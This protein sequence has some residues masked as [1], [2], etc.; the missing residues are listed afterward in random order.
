MPPGMI[1][2]RSMLSCKKCSVKRQGQSMAI[3]KNGNACKYVHAKGELSARHARVCVFRRKSYVLASP[4][5]SYWRAMA[6]LL[7]RRNAE[8]SM[9]VSLPDL[10][11]P[12]CSKPP[13]SDVDTHT[14][15]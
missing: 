15:S 11:G 14:P 4:R 1:K 2:R 8:S 7:G 6:L 10:V 12:A 9:E 13:Q 3:Q 5:S